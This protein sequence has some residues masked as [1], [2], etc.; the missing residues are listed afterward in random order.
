[1]ITS[2]HYFHGL[3]VYRCVCTCHV[4]RRVLAR[5][6]R[7]VNSHQHVITNMKCPMCLEGELI[8]DDSRVKVPRAVRIMCCNRSCTFD[9][10]HLLCSESRIQRVR[11]S[12]C[13][14]G[15]LARA[16]HIT[17]LCYDYGTPSSLS[18]VERVN[19]R[20]G[21]VVQHALGAFF[22]LSLISTEIEPYLHTEPLQ[23][24]EWGLPR[25][26]NVPIPVDNDEALCRMLSPYVDYYVDYYEKNFLKRAPKD[27]YQ[28]KAAS[29]RYPVRPAG[30]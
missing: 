26:P 20:I 16:A 8:Q 28:R 7:V 2:R 15:D 21:E 6:R 29:Q 25:I 18:F 13:S 5:R 12:Y 3:Y 4:R 23:L 17:Q 24:S 19:R 22:P 11:D 1:M 27:R 14:I 30:L 9:V 10:H